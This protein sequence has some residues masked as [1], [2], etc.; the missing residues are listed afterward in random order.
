MACA[1][2]GR[3]FNIRCWVKPWISLR[4]PWIFI[5]RDDAKTRLDQTGHEKSADVYVNEKTDLWW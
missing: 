4:K 3:G 2:G 5:T 1:G